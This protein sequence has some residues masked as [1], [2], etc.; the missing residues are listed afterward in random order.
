ERWFG[1]RGVALW[2]AGARA[3]T[4]ALGERGRRTEGDGDAQRLQQLPAREP[5]MVEVLEQRKKVGTHRNA[6]PEKRPEYAASDECLAIRNLYGLLISQGEDRV[7][8]AR[9]MRGNQ[10]GRSRH[11]RQQ[12]HRPAGHPGIVGLN[13]VEL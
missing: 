6:P 7:D 1:W 13:A 12:H 10:P 4:L 5:A 3:A 11:D 2:C 8:A 9:A